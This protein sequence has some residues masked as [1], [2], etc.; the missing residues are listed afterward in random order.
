L[1]ASPVKKG[2]TVLT[3]Q[4][5]I[6]IRNEKK[7]HIKMLKRTV[8]DAEMSLKNYDIENKLKKK[9]NKECKEHPVNRK[10]A[11]AGEH[12]EKFELAFRYH[13][14]GKSVRSSARDAGVP[15][16]C[17]RRQLKKGDM[18]LPKMGRGYTLPIDKEE[19]LA[20]HILKCADL[21]FGLTMDGIR[22]LAYNIA[23]ELKIEKGFSGKR[24]MA[25]YTWL[26]SFVSR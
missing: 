17:F 2:P 11:D 18:N 21:G 12:Q 26:K 10:W 1:K 13:A 15:Y 24:N 19:Q 22:I 23:K 3:V 5:K 4:E 25:G 8:K 16:S 6:R 9:T 14:N 20:R 7:E